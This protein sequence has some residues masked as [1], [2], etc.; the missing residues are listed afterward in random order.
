M[1]TFNAF[2]TI[3]TAIIALCGIFLLVGGAWMH[4]PISCTIG[5]V[6]TAFPVILWSTVDKNKN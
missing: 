5:A 6:A 2:Q 3:L 4:N 1:K